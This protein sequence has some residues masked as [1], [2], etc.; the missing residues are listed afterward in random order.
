[1]WFWDL[2]P[3]LPAA[4]RFIVRYLTLVRV[5]A[6]SYSVRHT[7]LIVPEVGLC[8]TSADFTKL[9]NVFCFLIFGWQLHNW[10]W[11]IDDY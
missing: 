6:T 3:P 10:P 5:T 1:M 9:L 4:T 2:A 11:N 8:P 7:A